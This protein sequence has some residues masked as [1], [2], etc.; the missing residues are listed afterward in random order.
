MTPLHR[1]SQ[2]PRL[3]VIT[4][5]NMVSKPLSLNLNET[6]LCRT[7]LRLA[8]DVL[9]ACCRQ[10]A[11]DDKDGDEPTL[12]SAMSVLFSPGSFSL[13]VAMGLLANTTIMVLAIVAVVIFG[14]AQRILGANL[15]DKPGAYSSFI[16]API[17]LVRFHYGR[18]S[19]SPTVLVAVAA[20][21]SLFCGM[22][23]FIHEAEVRLR[24]LPSWITIFGLRHPSVFPH[25]MLVC[26]ARRQL[27]DVVLLCLP[28]A[29]TLAVHDYPFVAVRAE[30]I[31][32]MGCG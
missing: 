30:D 28:L 32:R 23:H 14:I 27:V 19:R 31:E 18:G 16:A 6:L 4:I 26:L 29:T 9:P 5:G 25:G 24:A 21:D 17:S 7:T 13:R 20:L 12:A 1:R 8:I 2:F 11:H 15:L 10:R 3:N 22:S